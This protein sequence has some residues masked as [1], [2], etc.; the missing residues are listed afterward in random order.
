MLFSL[1]VEVRR[2]VGFYQG[3]F[4]ECVDKVGADARQRISSFG[5]E[6]GESSR[7]EEYVVQIAATLHPLASGEVQSL[8]CLVDCEE[9]NC[10]GARVDEGGGVLA[11][12]L[13]DDDFK[14]LAPAFH[15]FSD[16][17]K[18]SPIAC[19]WSRRHVRFASHVEEFASCEGLAPSVG[20]SSCVSDQAAN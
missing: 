7:S 10:C 19:G 12:L 4:W 16:V 5:S 15:E 3:A 9:D 2:S 13:D 11:W 17:P 14:D 1:C 20:L 18:E 6:A 8:T